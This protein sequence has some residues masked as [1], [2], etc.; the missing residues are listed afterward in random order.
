M[1]RC[2]ACIICS[3]M[4]PDMPSPTTGTMAPGAAFTWMTSRCAENRCATM[5]AARS[6]ASPEAVPSASTRI[7]LMVMPRSPSVAIGSESCEARPLLLDA[8]RILVD[9]DLR[10]REGRHDLGLDGIG[11]EMR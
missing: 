10:L 1:V 3:T 4:A 5:T 2:I 6:A 11:D 9:D 7:D 8:R